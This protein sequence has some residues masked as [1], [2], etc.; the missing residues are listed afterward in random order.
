M[1]EL[2]KEKEDNLKKGR[3][4]ASGTAAPMGGGGESSNKG[5]KVPSSQRQSVL[6]VTTKDTRRRS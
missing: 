2:K 6:T 4:Y 3:Q 5:E 1:E